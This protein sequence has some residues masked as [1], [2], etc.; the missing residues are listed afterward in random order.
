MPAASRLAV[1]ITLLITGLLIT[2]TLPA[3]NHA[4][5]KKDRII[6]KGDFPQE[7]VRITLVKVKKGPVEPNKKFT[8]SDDEWL[9]GFT[10]RVENTSGKPINYIS[11]SLVI[12]RPEEQEAA[13]QIPFSEWL[14][15]GVSPTRPR[16]AAPIQAAPAIPPGGNT[17]LTLSDESFEVNKTL[18]KRLGFPDSIERVELIVQ[19]VGFEDGTLWVGGELWRRDPADPDKWVELNPPEE[20][21]PPSRSGGESTR[22]ETSISIIA[23]GW[24]AEPKGPLFLTLKRFGRITAGSRV[25]SPASGSGLG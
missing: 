19:D 12:L 6:R 2:S 16:N 9:K 20:R 5:Q 10:L 7:P 14:S 4:S 15:Y 13:G 24:M 17:E 23:A 1:L 22:E 8:D 25:R 21:I 3:V 18:L 11:V